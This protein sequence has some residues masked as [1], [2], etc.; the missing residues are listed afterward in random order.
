MTADTSVDAALQQLHDHLRE[1][2]AKIYLLKSTTQDPYDTT[3]FFVQYAPHSGGIYTDCGIH[4]IDMS[5]WLLGGE[6]PK[7]V[8]A[9]GSITLVPELAA[10]GDVD[11]GLAVITFAS[12]AQCT[13]HLSRTGMGGY[14]SVVEAFSTAG[15]AVVDT[16]AVARV[17]VTDGQGRRLPGA[18]P[19]YIDRF[20]DAFVREAAAF[21][22]C[23]LDD[24]RKLCHVSIAPADDHSCAHHRSRRSPGRAYRQG[25]DA[26]AQDWPAC[27]I[28]RRRRAAVV[29]SCAGRRGTWHQLITRQGILFV[30]AAEEMEHV[31][32]TQGGGTS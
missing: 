6:R 2:A 17:A 31:L 9:T 24:T 7:S 29:M 8:Y 13:L 30:A 12:G 10:L 1:S 21:V 26:L 3:G 11:N 5:R 19:S 27:G 15:K 16:P 23:V 25:S 32:H 22:D 14:E 4:D 28:R 18:G 20:G